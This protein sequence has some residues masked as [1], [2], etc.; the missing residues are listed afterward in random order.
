MVDPRYR[1]RPATAADR[2]QLLTLYATTRADELTLTGWP[3]AQ[4][5]AFAEMQFDAQTKHYSQHWP[6]SLCH[7]ILVD[8]GRGCSAEEQ[9]AGRLWLDRRAD[10]LHVLDISLLPMYRG[11]G[12]G[13]RCLRDLMARAG[14]EGLPLSISVEIHNPARR[15]YQRLGFNAQGEPLGL[16]Q[17]MAWHPASLREPMQQE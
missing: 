5:L 13:S 10:S 6:Q 16:Y 14:A 3:E 12:L 4:C 11:Q 9:V 17:R 7:L 8:V 2:G 1:L 15:L